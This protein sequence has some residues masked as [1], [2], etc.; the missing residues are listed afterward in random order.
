MTFL[1]CTT[2]VCVCVSVYVPLPLHSIFWQTESIRP[3][4]MQWMDN[5][6]YTSQIEKLT[7]REKEKERERERERERE[8]ERESDNSPTYEHFFRNILLYLD[9]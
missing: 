2:R 9:E 3:Q 8:K 7:G 6:I 5:Q 1:N 4:S